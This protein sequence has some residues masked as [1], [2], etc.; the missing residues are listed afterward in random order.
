MKDTEVKTVPGLDIEFELRLLASVWVEEEFERGFDSGVETRLTNL[1][2]AV[3][4]KA[5]ETT[6][7]SKSEEKIEPL[8]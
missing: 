4:R 7:N 5:I 1:L 8:P 6:T 3:Y 2:T